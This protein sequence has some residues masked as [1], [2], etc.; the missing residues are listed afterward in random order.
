MDYLNN[1]SHYLPPASNKHIVP[2]IKVD[3]GGN[4]YFLVSPCSEVQ[5][6][7][8]TINERLELIGG[9]F[10]SGDTN[11]QQ[12]RELLGELTKRVDALENVKP[13]EPKF[14]LDDFQEEL[15]DSHLCPWFSYVPKSGSD[16]A[17]Y[18][19]STLIFRYLP[20]S[21]VVEVYDL[22]THLWHKEVT[23]TNFK[24]KFKG[25]QFIKASLSG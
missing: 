25:A 7:T 6:L 17:E 9:K 10:T 23:W 8:T 14:G 13:M 24:R 4:E 12:L 18:T 20:C 15:F 2:P 1:P 22:A 16:A 19:T 11:V 21:D 5:G 3:Q